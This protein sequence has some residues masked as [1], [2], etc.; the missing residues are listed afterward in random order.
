MS[1]QS[2]QRK[3]ARMP[4]FAPSHLHATS[5]ELHQRSV[6]FPLCTFDRSLPPPP[7]RR[8]R[9]RLA[10]LPARRRRTH[11]HVHTHT[12]THGR[13]FPLLYSSIA[14]YTDELLWLRRNRLIKELA[15]IYI[16]Q[17]VWM[18]RSPSRC[19]HPFLLPVASIDLPS[20]VM[21]AYAFMC[22]VCVCARGGGGSYCSRDARPCYA[23]ASLFCAS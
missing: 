4:L 1:V 23:F 16:V 12:R 19:L 13:V 11:T 17:R 8:R 3:R 2:G 14:G 15:R 20:H 21:H 7:P 10:R 6:C 5:G 18:A 9:R 22:G